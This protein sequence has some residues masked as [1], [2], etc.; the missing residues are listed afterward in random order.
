MKL[1]ESLELIWKSSTAEQ[2]RAEQSRAEQSRAE[3]SRAE[4]SRAK[5]KTK[6]SLQESWSRRVAEIVK[7]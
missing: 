2:S 4:Q 1:G 5:Q 7:A 6:L 3:Q